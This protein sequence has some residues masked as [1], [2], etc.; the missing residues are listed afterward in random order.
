MTEWHRPPHTPI[1]K[2]QALTDG[3][4]RI[5][6][7]TA[8]RRIFVASLLVL[9]SQLGWQWRSATVALGER[10]HVTVITNPIAA[11]SAVTAEDTESRAWPIGLTPDGAL[12]S[13][14]GNAVA[15]VD[16]VAGEVLVADRLFPS[17][18]GLATDERMVT[19]AQPLAPP[20]VQRGSN[21]ELFGIL[22]LGDGLTTPATRLTRGTVIDVS[23]A[24]ISIA[25]QASA[26]PSVVEHA[27][28]GTVEVVILP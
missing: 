11:G 7:R 1:P 3:I 2:R 22:P 28:L 24:S 6:P 20:P 5:D 10:H 23:D 4:R 13:L 25:V 18:N 15:A 9:L 16:L 17:A 26:V 27:A 19:I 8:A 21:V 14:P 12:S